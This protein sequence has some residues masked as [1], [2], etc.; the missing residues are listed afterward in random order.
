MASP[1]RSLRSVSPTETAHAI[2]AVPPSSG[3]PQTMSPA[4][5]TAVIC[6]RN[7]GE[8]VVRAAASVLANDH[9]SFRVVVV[10][11][12]SDG[13]SEKAMERLLLDPRLKY[14]KSQTIGVSRARNEGLSLADTEVVCFTDDDCEVP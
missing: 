3:R 13:L 14:V 9:P 8:A 2:S 12:S 4:G 11:Q 6:T 1:T 5:I 7:R 10:D